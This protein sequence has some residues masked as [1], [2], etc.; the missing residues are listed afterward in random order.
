M[1]MIIG[2]GTLTNASANLDTAGVQA[3]HVR[4]VKAVTL[5]NKTENDCWV[6]L[7]FDGTNILYKYVIPGA[8]DREENTRT[9]PFVDQVMTEGMRIAGLAQVSSAIDYYISGVEQEVV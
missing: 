9:I 4:L 5:C 8:G 6:T 7:R 2:K 3:G 1:N